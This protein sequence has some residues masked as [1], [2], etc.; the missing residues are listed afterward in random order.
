M[1]TLEQFAQ[2]N[3]FDMITFSRNKTI[4]TNRT[5]G[6]FEKTMDARI[7]SG[8]KKFKFDSP[9]TFSYSPNYQLQDMDVVWEKT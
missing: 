3:N 9:Q 1:G 8:G 6:Q 2:D 5:G 7:A 4:R